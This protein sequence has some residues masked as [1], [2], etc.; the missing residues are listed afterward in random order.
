MLGSIHH[1]AAEIKSESRARVAGHIKDLLSAP[2]SHDSIWQNLRENHW[3]GTLGGIALR[4][5]ES[6][7][8][9]MSRVSKSK[10]ESESH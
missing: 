5:S 3:Q 2:F 8:V 9:S 1:S 10:F 6:A 7:P 4:L